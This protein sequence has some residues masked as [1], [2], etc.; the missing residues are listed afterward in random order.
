MVNVGTWSPSLGQ[1]PG[2]DVYSKKI[3]DAKYK[4]NKHDLAEYVK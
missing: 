1:P 4:I 2:A 3:D